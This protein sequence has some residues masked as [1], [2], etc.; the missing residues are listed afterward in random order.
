MFA[1]RYTYLK[2][3]NLKIRVEVPRKTNLGVQMPAGQVTV[4]EI[5]GDKDIELHAGQISISSTHAWDYRDVNASVDIGEVNA[6]VYG[7]EKGGF[8]R[9]FRKENPGGE[10]RLH[11]HI[12][13]GQIELLGKDAHATANS[14]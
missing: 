4:D 14:Q 3:G 9:V 8:F 11:A 5:V 7:A 1:S 6:Q 13:T 2:H 10:Y 12:M